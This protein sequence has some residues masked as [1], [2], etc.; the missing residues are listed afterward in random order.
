MPA[1][2]HIKY[3][4]HDNDIIEV[5]VFVGNSRFCGTARVYVGIGQLSE[6]AALLKGFPQR[7][8]D[9]REVV[10]GA[11]G[12]E[13]AGGGVRLHFYC[14]DLAGHAVVEATIEA[15]HIGEKP[16]ESAVVLANIE[17]ASL[18]LFL[19]QLLLLEAELNG[20]ASL[21]ILDN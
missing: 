11:F 20:V 12:R 10:L 5:E 19:P 6:A 8:S 21:R 17:P 4:Y 1:G 13:F 18:D 16:A 2:L 15:D 3:L 7:S 9:T 14:K